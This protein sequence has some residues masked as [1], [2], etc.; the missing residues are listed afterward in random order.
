MWFCSRNPPREQAVSFWI[1]F[2]L[3]ILVY[4]QLYKLQHDTLEEPNMSQDVAW[5][6]RAM[7]LE[8]CRQKSYIS[9]QGYFLT[10]YK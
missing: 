6:V 2:G 4:T 5:G 1:N 8:R 7:L 3:E 10:N 9:L